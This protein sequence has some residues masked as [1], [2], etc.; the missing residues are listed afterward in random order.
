MEQGLQKGD[1]GPEGKC[2][3]CTLMSLSAPPHLS[4]CS[5]ISLFRGK[6]AAGMLGSLWPSPMQVVRLC[7]DFLSG[8]M[9][10]RDEKQG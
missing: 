10:E 3:L 7:H 2:L 6:E 8:L 9:E 1:Q 5:E 4:P